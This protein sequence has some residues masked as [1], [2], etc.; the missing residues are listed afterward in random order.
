M[1]IVEACLFLSTGLIDHIN[2]AVIVFLNLNLRHMF[3]HRKEFCGRFVD[4]PDLP[5]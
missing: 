3:S 2:T 5:D 1:V 4:G